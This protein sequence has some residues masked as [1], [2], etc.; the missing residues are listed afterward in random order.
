MRWV[1]D[2]WRDTSTAVPLQKSL[3]SATG[4]FCGAVAAGSRV[5]LDFLRTPWFVL[6]VLS[7]VVLLAIWLSRR[8]RWSPALTTPADQLRSGGQIYRSAWQIYRRYLPL[9]IGI[10]LIFIPL[11]AIAAIVQQATFSLTGIGTLIS[12]SDSDPVVEAVIALGLGQISTI[13][14]TVLVIA[15]ASVALAQMDEGEHPD[16]IHAYRG[17]MSHLGSLA[18]AWLRIV[19]VAGLLTITIVGIP[20]AIFYLVRKAVVTPACV[21]EDRGAGSSLRRSSELV[22][23]SGIRVFAVTALVAVTAY[24]AGPIVG[25]LVLFLT[26]SSLAAINVISSLVYVVVMPYVGVAFALL[27]YDLRHRL[28]EQPALMP[29]ALA[30]PTT[31]R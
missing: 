12:E 6:G 2:E 13:V 3:S 11:S 27:F 24:L 22:R 31:S 21:L 26:S 25:V 4:F 29:V 28:S 7:A 14:A 20:I 5:Y 8:T 23:G 30:A 17:V 10:G 19:L 18:W 15:A 16:A 1:E 9:F